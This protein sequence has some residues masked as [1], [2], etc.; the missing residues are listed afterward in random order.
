MN[1]SHQPRSEMGLG[2]RSSFAREWLEDA[3]LQQEERRVFSAFFSGYVA[4][5]AASSQMAGDHGVYKRYEKQ[6][7]EHLE[8]KAI[9]FAMTQRAVEIDKFLISDEGVRA[10]SSLRSREVPEGDNFKMIG[11]VNDSELLTATAFLFSLWSPLANLSKGKIEIVSQANNLG[12]IF[13]KVRNRLFHGGKM[14]DPNGTDADLL[15]R[16]NPILFG[17]V[18]VLVVH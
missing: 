1:S 2:D 6:P 3:R 12:L 17:I 18:E 11:S 7:D 16:L 15:E 10:T 13:R 4:L 8:R 5:V 9:E 14:N